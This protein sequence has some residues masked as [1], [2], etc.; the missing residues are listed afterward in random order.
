[1]VFGALISVIVTLVAICLLCVPLMIVGTI[2][3]GAF[4]GGIIFTVV[5]YGANDKKI[6]ELTN[7][8]SLTKEKVQNIKGMDRV[9]QVAKILEQLKN[10]TAERQ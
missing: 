10:Q 5:K 8:L 4:L 1:L 9:S 6:G 3:F 2:L 7:Q